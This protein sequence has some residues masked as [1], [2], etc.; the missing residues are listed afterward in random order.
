MN[1][2]GRRD[3]R[4]SDITSAL[5]GAI[6]KRSMC[7]KALRIRTRRVDTEKQEENPMV[8]TNQCLRGLYWGA[9]HHLDFVNVSTGRQPRLVWAPGQQEA[10]TWPTA[11]VSAEGWKPVT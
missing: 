10:G 8:I 7:C 6:P 4:D 2:R 11:A 1:L 3:V 5:T 9:C